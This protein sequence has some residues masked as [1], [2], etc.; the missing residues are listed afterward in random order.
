VKVLK[1]KGGGGEGTS[2]EYLD[3]NRLKYLSILNYLNSLVDFVSPKGEGKFKSES[4]QSLRLVK[5]LR[6][7]PFN[8]I[9]T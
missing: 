6:F 4:V 5:N 8:T 2:N 9:S 7:G 1:S 3:I